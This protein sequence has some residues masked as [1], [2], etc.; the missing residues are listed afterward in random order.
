MPKKLLNVK[1]DILIATRKLLSE[2]GYGRFD[3]RSIASCC[4]IAVGTLYN[5][6]KSKQEIV[7]EILN[8]EW[9]MMFRRIEQGTKT[10]VDLIDRLEI[11]YTELGI[12]MKDIHNMW[13]QNASAKIDEDE[14]A[15][16]KCYKDMLEESLS[17]KIR[18]QIQGEQQDKD[19]QF[20][21]EIICKLFIL[22]SHQ[23]KVAFEKLKPIIISLVK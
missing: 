22:Y 2:K 20:I 21:A 1:E 4:G 11:I 16:I 14:L 13:F 23:G 7:E 17:G 15:R 18:L 6:Y 12:L 3:V 9:S 10:E 19:Y 8:T 5:Y